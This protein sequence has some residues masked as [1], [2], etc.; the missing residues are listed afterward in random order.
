MQGGGGNRCGTGAL[1][2]GGGLV[3]HLDVEVSGAK[4]SCIAFGLDQH[5][6]QDR[7]GVA[8]FNYRLSLSHSLQQ[9]AAFDAD[10]HVPKSSNVWPGEAT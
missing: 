2:L 9:G 3:D 7:N 1:H 8:A 10:L 5:V 6:R 4:L